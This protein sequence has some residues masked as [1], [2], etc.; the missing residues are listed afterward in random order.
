[1]GT[2]TDR[3]IPD[4]R[5][6]SEAEPIYETMPGWSEE[7]DDMT[8][9]SKLP[10]NASRYIERIEQIVGLPVEIVSVGPKRTQTLAMA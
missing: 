8:D 4:A 3:F 6:L 10:I 2:L 7:I 1:D 9:R 5:K